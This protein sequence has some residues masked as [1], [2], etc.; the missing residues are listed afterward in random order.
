M[1]NNPHLPDDYKQA[2]VLRPGAQGS[3]EIIGD[4]RTGGSHVFEYLRRNS[5][6]PWG[7]YAANMANDAVRYSLE[8]LCLDDMIGMRH[9]YYQRTYERMAQEFDIPGFSA[10]KRATTQELEAVRQKIIGAFENGREPSFTA[11]L[12]GWN[13]GF[14]F[15]PTGYRL[16]ASHQMLHQQFALIPAALA[17][18]REPRQSFA[19]GDLIASFCEQYREETGNAFFEDYIAAIRANMRMDDGP[20]ETSLIIYED[21]HVMVFVPKAQTSQW[22]VQIMTTSQ[23]GNILELSTEARHSLDTAFYLIVKALHGIGV[24]LMSSIEYSKRF[25]SN[26]KDQRLL[27]ALLPKLPNSPGAF[28]E[29]QLRWISGH[30][31]EDLATALR[32]QL[33]SL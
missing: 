18:S 25:T 28:S 26:N 29:S 17:E 24:K 1:A 10:R 2:M 12:W 27:Y 19:C 4:F 11:T 7:H 22:E 33:P 21:E 6:I 3:S 30:F 23:A 14:D 8:D 20:G 32:A 13:Y 15:A 9:L 5:Y 31:P 16:N